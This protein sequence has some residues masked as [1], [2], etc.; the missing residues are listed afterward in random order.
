MELLEEE[1]WNF[2]KKGFAMN[3][4]F[5]YEE[6]YQ[7][8]ISHQ[9]AAL[10][11][12]NYKNRLWALRIWAIKTKDGKFTSREYEKKYQETREEKIIYTNL[13]SFDEIKGYAIQ[14]NPELM[15]SKKISV[16]E[17]FEEKGTYEH[18][19]MDNPQNLYGKKEDFIEINQQLFPEKK[20][21]EI[22]LWNNEFTQYYNG[23]REGL[24]A[25]LWTIYDVEYKKFIVIDASLII[26]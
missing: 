3:Y 2:R 9:E 4:A 18:A 23:G 1:T 14:V 17:F 20:R 22:Y 13:R 16:E 26:D 15:N 6:N 5:F 24:G 7:K 8:I 12:L 19:F 11:F 21:L 10:A 25:Y